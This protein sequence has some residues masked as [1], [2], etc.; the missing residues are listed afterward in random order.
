MQPNHS[1]KMKRSH[2]ICVLFFIFGS[3]SDVGRGFSLLYLY[4]EAAGCPSLPSLFQVVLLC[5]HS[6]MAHRTTFTVS[7]LSSIAT[8]S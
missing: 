1:I 2:I 7:S 5:V 4:G 6:P 3:T 8:S